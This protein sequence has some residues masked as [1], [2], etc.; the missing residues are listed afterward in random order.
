MKLTLFTAVLHFENID[1]L[2][3]ILCLFLLFLN[4]ICC[5]S[6]SFHYVNYSAWLQLHSLSSLIVITGTLMYN[7]KIDFIIIVSKTAFIFKTY[8]QKKTTFVF[9]LFFLNEKK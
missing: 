4:T 7:K 8:T 3:N 6:A 5:K 1:L 9:I 2:Y